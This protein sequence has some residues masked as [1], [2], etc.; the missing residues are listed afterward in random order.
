[1]TKCGN[2]PREFQKL[3]LV[4]LIF[5]QPWLPG[6]FHIQ[7]YFEV[8]G[9]YRTKQESSVMSAV[10]ITWCKA[11]LCFASYPLGLCEG[12]MCCCL[13]SASQVWP[14][15]VIRRR[16]FANTAFFTLSI[17]WAEEWGYKTSPHYSTWTQQCPSF[18]FSLPS[19]HSLPQQLIF[20]FSFFQIFDF[21]LVPSIPKLPSWVD[22][23]LPCT[24]STPWLLPTLRAGD[25]HLFI[26]RSQCARSAVV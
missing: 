18:I 16:I 20:V 17:K 25:T 7:H 19:F 14:F 9:K 23:C 10:E 11:S 5:Y 13:R 12:S 24:F 2:A 21:P 1:M 8:D 15:T 26:N 6:Y 22:L 3:C 4:R